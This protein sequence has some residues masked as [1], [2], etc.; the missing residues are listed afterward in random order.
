MWWGG[1]VRVERLS[2]TRADAAGGLVGRV[3]SLTPIPQRIH[4]AVAAIVDRIRTGG[5]RELE[6][7]I[8]EF[9]VRDIAPKPLRVEPDE[10]RDAL[11]ALD[12]G[13]R[14]G[15]SLAIANV[16]AVAESALGEDLEVSLE[17]GQRVLMREIPVRRAAI[18][19]PGG[20]APYPSTVVMGAVTARVAGVEEVAVCSP[21]G[22]GGDV[23]GSVL[24]ACALCGV[25][26]VLRMGGAHAIAAFAYGTES[27]RRTDVIAGPGGLYVQEAKRA[28]SAD[29]GVDGFHGPSDLLVVLDADDADLIE[30]VALD[31]RAQAE[32]GPV[33]L[34]IAVSPSHDA[35]DALAGALE[36]TLDG[37]ADPPGICALITTQ[38]LE[39]A[40]AF[41]E[42][43]AP[44]HLQL[45]G[46]AAERLAP[47]VRS[48]GCLFVGAQSG[49]AFGDYVAGSNH[50]LPTAGAAR[51]SSALSP[52]HFRRRMAQVDLGSASAD[53]AAA[54]AAVA[55]LEGF[56]LHARSME[57]R[58]LE[59]R[60]A[61]PR[62]PASTPARGVG[63]NRSS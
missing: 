40:L 44:E 57:A 21:P 31:L 51:F 36:G 27:V 54:G 6:A 63:D 14:A 7:C 4:E 30:L 23:D 13:A 5:D 58:A 34:V 12:A 20:R 1:C 61:A 52:R 8:R 16:T 45:I 39:A 17:Q 28:V 42:A 47:R 35:I 33:S 41:A 38:D 46:G 49:T 50:I 10:L 25:D 11:D 55:R 37:A 48:A 15:L 24:A 56:E 22:P 19:V 18:Y 9:D 32:H 62:T 59:A 2:L 3:R 43:Y 29:V 26:E 60:P 53:L